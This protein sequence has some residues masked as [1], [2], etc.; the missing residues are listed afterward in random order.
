[1]SSSV[2]SAPRYA[3][4]E[5]TFAPPVT[6][7]WRT[8]R[9]QAWVGLRGFRTDQELSC[10]AHALAESGARGRLRYARTLV[11]LAGTPDL[12]TLTN[13]WYARQSIKR[14]I[15]M[16]NTHQGTRARLICGYALLALLVTLGAA[17]APSI[18]A[19]AIKVAD[20]ELAREAGGTAIPTVRINPRYPREAVENKT[21]GSVTAEFTITENGSVE[22]IVVLES[23]PAGVFDQ[24][25]TD[26][27]AE[28]RFEPWVKNGEA[29][30]F[31]ATQT[32]EFKID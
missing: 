14:R 3:Q 23:E 27:L 1:M 21:Q 5:Y 15:E 18:R 11:T 13:P 19:D 28:W 31:R 32:I 30:P 29:L 7:R 8:R 12:P 6:A 26:A 25:A 2:S 4:S 22:E 16:L 17:L 10:D 20:A 24:V 9:A